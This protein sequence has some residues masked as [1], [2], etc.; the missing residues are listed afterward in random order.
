MGDYED[1]TYQVPQDGEEP[2][3]IMCKE[4]HLF[5]YIMFDPY[6]GAGATCDNC[7]KQI[8]CKKGLYHC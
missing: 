7:K 5:D 2:E 3:G 8:K 1:Q 4:G 6:F